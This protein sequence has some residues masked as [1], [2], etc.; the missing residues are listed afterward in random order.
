MKT[1]DII[2]L[3]G[4]QIPGMVKD[5]GL[6]AVELV[7]ALI[8]YIDRIEPKIN[9]WAYFR[10]EILLKE[11]EAIDTRVKN[12]E[13]IGRLSAVPV[14][15]KD[16]FNTKDMPTCM[17]SK[18]WDG[19][20]PGNDARVVSYL[21]WEDAIVFGK[22]VTAE[23]AVHEPGPTRNPHDLDYY[24]G[25]SS[26][27]SAASVAS[28]MVPV[29]LGTQTAGSII[30]PASYCGVYGFKPSF[31]T[32]P[33]TAMLKTTDTLD[34]VG[35][36]TRSI[37]DVGLAFDVMRVKGE[38]FPF[39]HRHM[40][41]PG[42]LKKDSW[43]IG[44]IEHP[45]WDCVDDYAR[46]GFSNFLKD[47]SRAKGIKLEKVV[48]PDAFN[49]AHDIHERIYNKT[50]AYYFKEES[51]K[52]EL[53][54][55]VLLGM[56]EEGKKLSLDDY[57]DAISRQEQLAGELDKILEGYDAVVTLSTS[58]QAPKFDNP[59]DKPDSCLIWSLCW[60]PALNI[61]VF[62]GPTG[63]PYGLQVITKRYRDLSLIEFVK[64]LKEK[65]IVVDAQIPEW[66]GKEAEL[67]GMKKGA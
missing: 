26:S 56:I 31:G 20:T 15:V 18:L 3:M 16:I 36:F 12:R 25:T 32:L 17:G 7:K 53:V 13:A 44:Y 47:L 54:S 52:K 33:R 40:D 49:D 39:V 51:K 5:Q 37:E 27:G 11:A 24:P 35:F 55:K 64:S 63:L 23:F 66:I 45:K 41:E 14:G 10:P 48:L 62:K 28:G 30:R 21:R 19:F 57:K 59:V 1:K 4:F 8:A 2:P 58:G 43:R 61:P 9:A 34:Q 42:D 38:N 65:G 6:T 60:V 67:A 22:T 29:A 46:E 50:L